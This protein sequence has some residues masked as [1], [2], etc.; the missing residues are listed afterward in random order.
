MKANF[1]VPGGSCSYSHSHIDKMRKTINLVRLTPIFLST[2]PTPW[3][4][5]L[6][7]KSMAPK[8][9]VSHFYNLLQWPVSDINFGSQ[10]SIWALISLYSNVQ[11]NITK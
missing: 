5:S 10:V 3:A 11:A 6:W 4:K 7:A 2:Y 1:L 8:N 9:V